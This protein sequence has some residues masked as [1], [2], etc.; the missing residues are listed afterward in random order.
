MIPARQLVA[1]ML[2]CVFLGLTIFAEESTNHSPL[3]VWDYSAQLAVGAGYR[4]NVLRSS[5]EIEDSFFILT[6]ADASLMRFSDSGAL[7]M[8]YF[9]GED[10]RYTDAP[11][12]NY[13][14]FL[15]ATAQIIQPV[16]DRSETG[17]EANYLYQHQVIDASATEVDLQRVLVLGHSASLRPHWKHRM[18]RWESKL[19]G[20]VTRQIFEHELD[21]YWEGEVRLTMT[22][23]YGHRS[24]FSIGYLPMLRLYDTRNQYDSSGNKIEGTDLTYL[25]NEVGGE[26]KHNLNAERSWRTASKLSYMVNCDNGSGYFDYDRL[27]FREQVRWVK[28][29]WEIKATGRL[30]WYFY[31]EQTV[32]DERRERSYAMLSIRAEHLLGKHWRLYVDGEHEWSMS[33]DPLD[34]YRSWMVSAGVGYEF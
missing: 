2:T 12:V 32:A 4:N 10:T 26:W 34:E 20:A 31:K 17:L 13:E 24:L 3:A 25:Q 5:I 11:S 18:G 33:N 9:Y 7:F 16:G 19:D 30:G 21:D 8:V 29:N 23:N 1:L 15:T 14:Q 27:L 6:S 22:R 28:G